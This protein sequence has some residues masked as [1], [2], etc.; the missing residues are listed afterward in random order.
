MSAPLMAVQHIVGKVRKNTENACCD[1]PFH[2]HCTIDASFIIP[3]RPVINRDHK[4]LPLPHHL[5][6]AYT[7]TTVNQQHSHILSW[8][9]QAFK[10]IR[11]YLY[12]L[13]FSGNLAVVYLVSRTLYKKLISL[14]KPLLPSL[15]P[16][17]F[18][19]QPEV[20]RVL[21]C[22]L[23][24]TRP[25]SLSMQEQNER[26]ILGKNI[27]GNGRETMEVCHWWKKMECARILQ[28]AE[29]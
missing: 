10:S 18:G 16:W 17:N 2:T 4:K 19:R 1:D 9:S 11:Q 23:N 8:S 6:V 26:R 14:Y 22:V 7:V 3:L 21:H 25:E 15:Q 28:D 27:G 29:V 13:F 20:P 12:I 24:P 5:V